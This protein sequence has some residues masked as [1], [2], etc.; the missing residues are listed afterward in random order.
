MVCPYAQAYEWFQQ[1]LLTREE[2]TE[3]VQSL[4]RRID[5]ETPP[6]WFHEGQL[7]AWASTAIDV[8]ITAGTQGGKTAMQSPWLAREIQRCG[9]GIRQLGFGRFIYAGP[10]LTLLEE[11]AIP[12][13]EEVFVEQHQL[14]RLIQ[15]NKPRFHF[16]PDGLQRL[17]GFSHCPVTIGFAYTKDSS[18]LESKTALAGVWDEAG[19]K[20]NKLKAY[21]A[22][23]R[24]LKLARSQ[25]YG[26]RLFGTT[27]Y[28][29][30]WFKTYVVDPA[31]A[32]QSG[33]E[34]YKFVSWMN[35]LVDEFE[36]RKDLENGM[37]LWEWQMMYLGEF[38]QPAGR[39]YD[40]FYT[41]PD[42]RSMVRPRFP[43]P[44]AWPRWVGVDFGLR[45]TAAIFI[46]EELDSSGK[47]TGRLVRYN[48][49]KPGKNLSVEA[50]VAAIKKLAGGV[51]MPRAIG[52]SHTEEDVRA[53]YRMAGLPIEEPGFSEVEARIL[54][55]YGE[56]AREETIVF[57][58]LSDYLD[59]KLSYSRE[60]DE[61]M[62]P[63]EKIKDKASYHL[64]DAEGYLMTKLRPVTGGWASNP[65]YVDRL[66]EHLRE[67]AEGKD[68]EIP[69]HPV[70]PGAP[71][72]DPLLEFLTNRVKS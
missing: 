18:N 59:E 32:K 62:K 49:Y 5:V 15:G 2:F 30:G 1:G 29:W 47:R 58:D 41:D 19:Q 69:V 20:E 7:E 45:N 67:K 34:L 57:S 21:R 72:S 71:R 68:Q 51:K 25:G 70:R 38:T 63:T 17:L 22:F 35:P 43:I 39:I 14:G 66:K 16:S 31:E 48:E 10:T 46:A 13:F 52:G 26:R 55:V 8:V 54:C 50:H 36:C 12:T 27:P 56:H 53:A 37:P 64:M 60:L 40:N 4:K 44:D 6:E 28:E 11:Q 33:F 3:V 23:N 42:S 61:N 65:Q 9:G 24:R